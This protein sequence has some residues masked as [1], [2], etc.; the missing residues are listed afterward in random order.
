MATGKKGGKKPKGLTAKMSGLE[1]FRELI[2]KGAAAHDAQIPEIL[3]SDDPEAVHRARVALRRLRSTLRGF[4]DMLSPD[5]EARLEQ[6]LAERFRRLGPLRDADVH[7]EALAGTSAGDVATD[8]AARLREALRVELRDAGWKPLSDEIAE[9]LRGAK[10][11][12]GGRRRRLA[13]APVGVIASRALQSA[14]TEMLAFGKHLDRLSEDD[15]HSFRKRAKDMRYLSEFF[16]PIWADR[17]EAPMVR[18]MARMQD[19][20]GL[21]NDLANMRRNARKGTDPDRL[22][23]DIAA[24]ESEARAEVDVSWKKLRKVA[25]WWC[26]APG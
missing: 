5:V 16:G 14:W 21:L 24:R 15:L 1:A 6:V 23:P 8:E 11:T 2:G 22:L 25:P 17:P 3:F 10:L 4:A 20:L 9:L 12:P 18:R 19:A 26:T 13:Q 7:A